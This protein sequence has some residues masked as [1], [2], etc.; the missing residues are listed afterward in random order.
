MM[1]THISLDWGVYR[2]YQEII[3]LAKQKGQEKLGPVF[4]HS[5]RKASA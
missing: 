5:L 1:N 3:D 4:T 2:L